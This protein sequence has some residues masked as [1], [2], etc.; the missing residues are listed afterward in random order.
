MELT[1]R[2]PKATPGPD[3]SSFTPT[4]P[5]VNLVPQSAIDRA[6]DRRARKVAI[7]GWVGSVVLIAGW[8]GTGLVAS[9]DAH[10]QLSKA[11]ADGQALA[12]QMA[13]YAP[14][15]SIATQTKA[16]NDTVASQTATE[17]NH[18]EV[19]AR[20]ITAVSG[21]MD[22]QSV[23]LSTGSTTGCVSTDPFKQ[24]ALAGCITFTGNA[25]AGSASASQII[26]S[27]SGN[28]WFSDPF[29]P[30]VGAPTAKGTPVSGTVGVTVDAVAEHANTTTTEK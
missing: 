27:L 14:V 6:A 16:L 24:V 13:T 20:F 12:L 3:L 15:T 17:I 25:T 5:R 22:I 8:W 4:H 19:L 11:N 28:T 2:K 30:T 26:T 29:I 23:Q 7:G 1:L 21:L 9:Q 18:D 10:D